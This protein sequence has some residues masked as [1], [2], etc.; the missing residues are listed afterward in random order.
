MFTNLSCCNYKALIFNS[1]S[2]K[3]YFPMSFTSR[4]YL[5]TKNQENI[6]IK[7]SQGTT[8]RNSQTYAVDKTK[9]VSLCFINRTIRKLTQF[10]SH[11]NKA[12]KKKRSSTLTKF[13]HHQINKL[14]IKLHSSILNYL[15][16]KINPKRAL[17]KEWTLNQLIYK[18]K[19]LRNNKNQF[20]T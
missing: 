16:L 9:V 13:G 12:G 19:S 11:L 14:K 1:S 18:D 6:K 4:F 20:I 15:I 2:S 8:L 17:L 5:C 3:Q 10:K 7:F